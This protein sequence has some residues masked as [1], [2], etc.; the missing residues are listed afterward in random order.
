MIIGIDETGSFDEDGQRRSFFIAAQLRQRKTLFKQKQDQFLR[1]EAS[2]P[3]QL[4]NSKGE[5]KSSALSDSQL[6][7]FARQ[8]IVTHYR[9]KVTPI[10]IRPA[11]NPPD[12]VAK[13]H[14]IM[15]KGIRAGSKWYRE[16][17]R[18]KLSA[19][20]NEFGNWFEKLNYQQFLK[21]LILCECIYS[22]FRDAIGHS[23]TGAYDDELV[24]LRFKID[25]DF[26]RE[27]RHEIFWRE[28]LRNILEQNSERRPLPILNRWA[29]RG[30]PF[31]E[32]YHGKGYFD[33]NELFTKNCD[34]VR[35]H[36]HFEIRIADAVS[37]IFT[38]FLNDGRCAKAYDLLRPCITGRGGPVHQLLL[39]DADPS[40]FSYED[41][42]QRRHR[43][44]A[45]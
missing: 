31:L 37:T 4:R 14:Q 2:V 38:R 33:F 36:E 23:I 19:L 11:D 30:H 16:N 5:L 3:R 12:I 21:V 27:P 6:L 26:I 28:I 13:H 22:S 7:D 20:Y 42:L 18:E 29:N 39:N 15:L 34:F 43:L 32:K 45:R 44:Q 8:V 9:V 1:W 24:R 17:D 35:S 41:P 40:K 10:A 25:R